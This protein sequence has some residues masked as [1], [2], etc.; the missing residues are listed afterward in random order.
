MDTQNTPIHVRL[1]HKEFWF[2]CIAHML[3]AISVYM[4]IPDMLG[5]MKDVFTPSW[6][7]L[8]M[9]AF[10]V[11]LFLPGVFVNYLVQRYP[12]RNVCSW[13]VLMLAVIIFATYYVQRSQWASDELVALVLRL[14]LG[15]DYSLAQMVLA[16]TLMVDSVES[17]QRTE[18]NHHASWFYRFALSLGPMLACVCYAS[19]GYSGI[20]IG[21]MVAVVL[22]FFFIHLVRFPFKAPEDDVHHVSLDR[23]FLPQATILFINLSMVTMVVGMLLTLPLGL[24]FYAFIMLGFFIALLSEKYVF[25]NADLRSENVT[26]MIS[27]ALSLL[28]LLYPDRIT[29]GVSMAATM[30]GFG[31]G[32]IGSR[33]LLFFIKLSDHC[34]RG[35]SQ[36]TF[37]LSWESGVA[38]GL[39]LGLYFFHNSHL[40][41]IYCS[42]A[43]IIIAL[44]FYLL[45]VHKWYMKHRN[46]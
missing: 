10:G 1:W 39:F 15:A 13:S 21:S 22:A 4:L 8:I 29:V 16:S 37:F 24:T 35:T 19:F 18:G 7:A 12:R 45:F 46:R 40:H 23:F 31:V 26:G 30:F 32:I 11:G 6:Q 14:A 28:I 42:L 3:L 41:L 33:F 43:I 36:S 38:C 27:I 2:L 44:I 25:A 34:Q 5:F 17:F 9:V 20:M